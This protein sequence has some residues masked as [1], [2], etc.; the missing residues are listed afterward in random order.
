MT[1][2]ILAESKPEEFV[3]KET[4]KEKALKGNNLE[5]T[6]ILDEELQKELDEI[7]VLM[8]KPFSK[9]ELLKLMAKEKLA[10]LRKKNAPKTKRPETFRKESTPE[11]KE[12]TAQASSTTTDPENSQAVRS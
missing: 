11:I 6:L 10:S 4:V 1:E 5:V 3:P 2:R 7:Q 9:L 8:G 12:S